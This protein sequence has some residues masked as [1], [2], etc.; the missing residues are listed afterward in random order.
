MVHDGGQIEPSLIGFDIGDVSEPDPVRRGSG[1]VPIEQIRGDREVVTAVGGPHPP[2][3]GRDGADNV[4]AHQP[5]DTAPAH[6][7]ALGLQLDMD[8]RAAIASACI[9]MDPLD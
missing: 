4:P 5:L 2:R 6:S 3:P 7:A 1:E 8:T 9:A